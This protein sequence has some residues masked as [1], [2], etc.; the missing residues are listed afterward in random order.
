MTEKIQSLVLLHGW[1]MS[2]DC[3]LPLLPLLDSMFEVNCVSLPGYDGIA[4]ARDTEQT[5]ALLHQQVSAPACWIGWSLGGAWAIEMASRMPELVS[6]LVLIGSNPSFCV[7]DDWG[8][9]L[10]AENLLRFK[11]GLEINRSKTLQ[12][13]IALQFMGVAGGRQLAK[14]LMSYCD[15]SGV[16]LRALQSGLDQLQDMDTR[17]ALSQLSIPVLGI[18]GAAD[19]LVPQAVAPAM[20]QLN[21]G[22]RTAVMNDAGHAPFI[23]H[24]EEIAD[25]I[26]QFLNQPPAVSHA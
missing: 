5:I 11:E 22:T 19:Q 25:I 2:A 13:F 9:A 20:K 12:Q 21:P 6:K 14:E 23:S 10:P 16:S 24:P 26:A 8:Q 4:E 15:V 1:G 17:G 18:F 3:W 7:R